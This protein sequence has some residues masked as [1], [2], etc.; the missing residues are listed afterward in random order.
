MPPS[1][2]MTNLRSGRMFRLAYVLL[3]CTAVAPLL[4]AEMFA[5]VASFEETNGLSLNSCHSSTASADTSM[6]EPLLGG[7]LLSAGLGL[8]QDFQTHFKKV[9]SALNTFS[10]P[11]S[12]CTNGSYP[13]SGLLLAINGTLALCEGRKTVSGPN[14]RLATGAMKWRNND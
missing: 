11:E 13:V 3:F 4:H 10:V 7:A 8:R 12:P 14:R 1:A 5:T 2:H 9:H 6:E